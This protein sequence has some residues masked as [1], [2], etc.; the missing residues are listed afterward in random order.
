MPQ[1]DT[2]DLV[3]HPL[4]EKEA[5]DIRELDDARRDMESR[6]SKATHQ[7]PIVGHKRVPPYGG[8]ESQQRRRRSVQLD[9]EINSDEVT[10]SI[11]SVTLNDSASSDRSFHSTPTSESAWPL[12]LDEDDDFLDPSHPFLVVE[13]IAIEQVIKSYEVWQCGQAAVSSEASQYT[14]VTATGN[15]V[16]PLDPR[17]HKRRH[18]DVEPS[19]DD[20]DLEPLT[21]KGTQ[22]TSGWRV[23]PCLSLSKERPGTSRSLRFRHQAIERVWNHRAREAASSKVASQKP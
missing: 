20:Q 14:A 18:D 13:S 12:S 3:T 9:D 10:R 1:L 4:E 6:L 7:L 23:S 8:P 21:K 2:T 5:V 15:P 22:T 19:E 17:Q 16:L 11:S